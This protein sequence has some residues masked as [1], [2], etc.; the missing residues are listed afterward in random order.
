MVP[1]ER[2]AV[3]DDDYAHE[4]EADRIVGVTV[5]LRQVGRRDPFERRPVDFLGGE[6]VAAVLGDLRQYEDQ[7]VLL[8]DDE[9]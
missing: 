2:P 8:P 5:S 4:V 9:G 6:P 7:V 1:E 3:A